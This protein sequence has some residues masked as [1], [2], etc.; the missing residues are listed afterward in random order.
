MRKV[1]KGG[2]RREKEK[3]EVKNVEQKTKK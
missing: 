3:I 1:R 2:G